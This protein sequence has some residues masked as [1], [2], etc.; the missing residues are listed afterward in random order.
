MSIEAKVA[1]LDGFSLKY[2]DF[3][4]IVVV[5][6]TGTK[7]RFEA[8]QMDELERFLDI[9]FDNQQQDSSFSE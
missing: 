5:E 7:T 1:R 4:S 3:G 8:Y 6:P 2:S 9:E